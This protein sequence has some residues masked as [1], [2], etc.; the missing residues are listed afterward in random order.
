MF[1]FLGKNHIQGFC[2]LIF[3]FYFTMIFWIHFQ[4]AF[5][6]FYWYQSFADKLFIIIEMKFANFIISPSPSMEMLTV[7]S[8]P[9]EGKEQASSPLEVER[10]SVSLFQR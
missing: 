5:F 8:S 10:P 3:F 7:S 9:R 2:F 4:V 1:H 6:F